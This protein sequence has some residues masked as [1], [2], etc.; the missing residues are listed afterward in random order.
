MKESVSFAKTFK[1]KRPIFGEMKRRMHK[2]IIE[3]MDKED[4]EYVE[5]LKL[6][7]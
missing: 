6:M 5:P 1:K 7:M 2:H 3:I 4:P